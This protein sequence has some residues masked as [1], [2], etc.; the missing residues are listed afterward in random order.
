MSKEIDSIRTTY[1]FNI[2]YKA[3]KAKSALSV[4][5]QIDPESI[6]KDREKEISHS[7]KWAEYRRG[8]HTPRLIILEKAE[9]KVEGSIQAFNHPLWAILKA[10]D[11]SKRKLSLI[12][13]LD[14][15]L[16]LILFDI[17]GKLIQSSNRH[18]LGKLERRAS[19]DSLAALTI[20]LKINLAEGKDE[21]AWEYAHS[22]TRVLLVIGKQLDEYGV[23]EEVYKIYCRDIFPSVSKNGSSFFTRHYLLLL[24]LSFDLDQAML[25][26]SEP[27]TAI[28]AKEQ[29]RI[30]LNLIYG[31]YS[32]SYNKLLSN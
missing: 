23:A 1:W 2:L 12:K 17:H 15:A 7:S 22:I 24:M 18:F 29:S 3:L 10:D 4:Q 16:Q 11:F 30:K 14:P 20:L 13:N 27:Q 9:T 21:I 31:I 5:R 32:E 6:Q 28:A 19:L 25:K 8:L 26:W